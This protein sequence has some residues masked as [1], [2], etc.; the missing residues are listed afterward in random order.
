MA[1]QEQDIRE[2]E[3][4]V[5]FATR[6][7]PYGGGSEEDIIVGFGIGTTEFFTR[8]RAAL[9]DEAITDNLDRAQAGA[10]REVCR[11]RLRVGQQGER[12]RF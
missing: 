5:D 2:Q 8:L 3:R 6:W 9:D 12:P 7:L 4:M 10:L 11:R 1:A